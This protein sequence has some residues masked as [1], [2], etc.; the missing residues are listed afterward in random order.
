VPTATT[1]TFGGHSL[2]GTGNGNYAIT[3]PTQAATITQ[4]SLTPT[5]TRNNKIYNGTLNATTIASRSVSGI[6]GSDDVTLANGT[7][8]A[9]S[10]KNVGSYTINVTSLSL[11]GTMTANYTLSSTS[12]SASANITARALTVSPAG[13]NKTYDGTNTATVTLSDDKVSG[14]SVTDHYTSATFSDKNM[15]NGKTVSVSGISIS[16]TDTANYSLQN[17]TASTTANITAAALTV[18]AHNTSKTYGDTVTFAGTEFSS[19]GL[20]NSD[21]VTS[22]TL[23]SSGAL[24]AAAAGSYD[25]VPSAATGSGLGNYTISYANGTLVVNSTQPTILSLTGA[26]TSSVVI[27]WS[28]ISN[29]TY[30][31]QYKPD[32][33]AISWSDLAGDVTAVGTNATKVDTTVSGMT[34]RFYR[35]R[36]LP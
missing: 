24:A 23:T 26:G 17:T 33:N 20:V 13:V 19:S 5:V 8:A 29:V 21:A 31:V 32:L 15:G 1:V 35:V 16:G 18:T 9:F 3:P 30:R 6:V 10:S 22:V 12:T 2:T 36:V 7:V 14:D 4:K 34:Q 11:S 28:A 25:I 27:N